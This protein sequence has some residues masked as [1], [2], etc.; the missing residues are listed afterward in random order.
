MVYGSNTME[1]RGKNK[2]IGFEIIVFGQILS[3]GAAAAS[4]GRPK[5]GFHA[6]FS[7]VKTHDT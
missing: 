2:N 4:S 7:C 5:R 1:P 6:F 3:R